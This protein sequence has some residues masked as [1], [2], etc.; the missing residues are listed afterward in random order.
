MV[1]DWSIA[2]WPIDDHENLPEFSSVAQR[3]REL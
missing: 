1:S 2:N 3:D